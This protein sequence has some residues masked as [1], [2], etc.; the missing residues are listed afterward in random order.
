MSL[1]KDV[2]F[3]NPRA[4]PRSCDLAVFLDNNHLV[5]E[6]EVAPQDRLFEKLL[7]NLLDVQRVL[8]T[9]PDVVTDHQGG[10]LAA[11]N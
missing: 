2:S 9:T 5:I 1:P 4:R 3:S 7:I 6:V 11:V 10:E 8:D